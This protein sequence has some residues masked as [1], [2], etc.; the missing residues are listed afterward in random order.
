MSSDG[1][2]KVETPKIKPKSSI[3]HV[4]LKNINN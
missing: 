4:P 3:A 1:A 2:P